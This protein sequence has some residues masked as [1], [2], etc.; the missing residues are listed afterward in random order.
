MLDE[1]IGIHVQNHN[2]CLSW[3]EVLVLGD[4][5]RVMLTRLVLSYNYRIAMS[6]IS[7]FI[8]L[9]WRKGIQVHNY[10]WCLSWWEVLVHSDGSRIMLRRLV[11]CTCVQWNSK[12]GIKITL[13]DF[14]AELPPWFENALTCSK[15][16]KSRKGW[17]QQICHT[18]YNIIFRSINCCV[19]TPLPVK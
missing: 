1:E 10:N 3:W 14:L 8:G 13:M 2:W 19:I 5:N 17:A 7:R 16:K 15:K 18:S 11:L 12:W 9:G 4:R 6:P